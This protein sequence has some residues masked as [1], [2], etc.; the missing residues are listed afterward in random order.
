MISLTAPKSVLKSKTVWANLL[1]LVLALVQELGTGWAVEPEWYVGIMTV[2]NLVLRLVTSQPVRLRT[3]D[4]PEIP[5]APRHVRR[6]LARDL[7]SSVT[8]NAN[9]LLAA[10]LLPV[11]LTF[12]CAGAEINC[13]SAGMVLRDSPTPGLTRLVFQCGDVDVATRDVNLGDLAGIEICEDPTLSLEPAGEGKTAIVV[14]CSGVDL[15]RF[16]LDTGTIFHVD[17]TGTPLRVRPV[18]VVPG[19]CEEATDAR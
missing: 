3:P 19:E 12:A 18:V 15:A 1:G 16:V 2:L 17:P 9:L 6:Q 11:L 4:D 14:T 7:A 8:R 13:P 5:A 10:L